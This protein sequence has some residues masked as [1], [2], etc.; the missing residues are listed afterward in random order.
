[1]DLEEVRHTTPFLSKEYKSTLYCNYRKQCIYPEK[2]STTKTKQT[3]NKT[4]KTKPTEATY[5]AP[6]KVFSLALLLFTL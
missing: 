5:S 1:M 2:K 4:N 3:K 6:G